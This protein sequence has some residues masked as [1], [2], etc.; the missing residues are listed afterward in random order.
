MAERIL[1]AGLGVF[2][3]AVA[4]KLTEL[5]HSVCGV[6]QDQE[7]VDRAQ[8]D[9]TVVLRAN[10]ADEDAVRE[11]VGAKHYDA[12]VLAIGNDLESSLQAA[13]HLREA[14]IPQIVARAVNATHEKLLKA[15][16]VDRVIYP[17]KE[18]GEQLALQI[19]R[20]RVLRTIP[21][22]GKAEIVEATAPER[23]A[24]KTL[25]E[26]SL[27]GRYG[28]TVVTIERGNRVIAPVGPETGIEVGD[29]LMLLGL[30]KDI[31]DFLDI[32]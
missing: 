9:I 1:V 22:A 25:A 18:A 12:A 10:L 26:L 7:L 24:G 30:P 14:G 21:L 27:R 23:V 6:D 3:R 2:G 28:I 17:E 32:A 19:G 11:I 15:V 5:G 31:Q 20:K 29:K 16:G 4:A 13:L 8:D